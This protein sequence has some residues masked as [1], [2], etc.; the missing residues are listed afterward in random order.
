MLLVLL[1][2]G[3]LGV[4]ISGARS[5]ARTQAK[6]SASV[7][8]V[9]PAPLPPPALPPPPP[10][11]PPE[12]VLIEGSYCTDVRQDCNRWLDDQALP[13][14]RCGEYSH[15]SRCV[16]KRVPM[17][18]CIDRREYTPPGEK[19]PL[20]QAS[21]DIAVKTCSGLGKRICTDN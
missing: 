20:N 14:A 10:P 8:A 3:G 2:V 19:L 18:F 6:P 11:C 7:A 12:M 21:Y 1:V 17:R 9:P 15:T 13:F 5:S 16:G 4:A